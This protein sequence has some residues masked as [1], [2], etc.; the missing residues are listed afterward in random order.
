MSEAAIAIIVSLIS[1]L[2]MLIKFVV[3]PLINKR[4]GNG[5]KDNRS[6]TIDPNNMTMGEREAM[7]R[8]LGYVTNPHKVGDSPMCRENRDKIISLETKVDN[9]TED[10]RDMRRKMN[11]VARG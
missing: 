8:R 1:L 5:D 7:A 3:V 9:L 4:N 11:G 2:T 10:V 6:I